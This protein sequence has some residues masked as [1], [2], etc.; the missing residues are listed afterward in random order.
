[1]VLRVSCFFDMNFLLWMRFG[2]ADAS[3]R[4]W[5]EE[6]AS[7]FFARFLPYLSLIRALR[8]RERRRGGRR[9]GKRSWF[10][11]KAAATFPFEQQ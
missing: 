6:V 8:P 9:R 5:F 11:V 1:M 2:Y 3:D 10:C 4:I 7:G